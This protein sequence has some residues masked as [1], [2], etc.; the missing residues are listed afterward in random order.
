MINMDLPPLEADLTSPSQATGP[1]DD[2]PTQE[3]DLTFLSQATGELEPVR[4]S[5]SRATGG[6]EPARSSLSRAA[7]PGGEA[8]HST[9]PVLKVSRQER[10]REERKKRKWKGER[11]S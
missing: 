3:A 4:S 5:L 6:L 7:E 1:G 8:G 9:I 11:D 2:L 10:R